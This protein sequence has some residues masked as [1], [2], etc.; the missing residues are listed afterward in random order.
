MQELFTKSWT[1]VGFVKTCF[2]HFFYLV[3][4]KIETGDAHKHLVNVVC[5]VKI[6]LWKPNV[7]QDHKSLPSTFIVRFWRD[8]VRW[9]WI[10]C[11]WTFMSSVKRGT[12]KAILLLWVSM[13]Y[14]YIC[15]IIFHGIIDLRVGTL[16]NCHYSCTGY[17]QYGQG[18]TYI[19]KTHY[20]HSFFRLFW[21]YCGSWPRILNC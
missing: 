6:G 13:N 10:K 7:T 9:I 4:I 12:G 3:W 14:I 20:L 8:F 21:E 15:T 1:S 17:Y 11:C 16:R 2:W 18:T 19:P 5:F